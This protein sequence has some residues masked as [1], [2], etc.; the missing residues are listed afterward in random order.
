M[1]SMLKAPSS[2]AND[3][4]AAT[5]WWRDAGV[6]LAFADDAT[7]WL[8]EPAL[9]EAQKPKRSAAADT[10]K[11]AISSEQA[12]PEE[13]ARI[14]PDQGAP[15]DLETFRQWWLKEPKLDPAGAKNRLAPRGDAK[16][17]LM[18]LVIDPEPEDHATLLSGPRGQLLAK[19]LSA[20]GIAENTVYFASVLPRH[21]PMADTSDLLTKGY[22]E[23]LN[24]HIKLAAPT[25]LCVFGTNIPPLLPHGTPDETHGKAGSL[26]EINHDGRI[27]PLFVAES[28]EG[29]M[30]SPSLKARFW[31]RWIKW[32]ERLVK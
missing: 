6:D 25:H 28:L 31:R 30:G 13:I 10:K 7:D 26:Q 5:D 29:L 1:M 21:T 16:A 18:V 8:A 15:T 22:A 11:D 17:Q 9:I 19:I 4:A 32:T 2:L 27:F 3:F 12:P 24:L 20:T 14:L 23:V